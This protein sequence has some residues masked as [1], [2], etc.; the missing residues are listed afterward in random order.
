MAKF[1]MSKTITLKAG[2][3]QTAVENDQCDVVE[4]YDTIKEA[5]QRLAM[6]PN[7]KGTRERYLF[8]TYYQGIIQASEPLRYAQILVNE[9]VIHDFFAAGY[10]GESRD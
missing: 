5:K 2:R 4:T 10:S 6:V 8:S 9:E 7:G 1:P 3:T